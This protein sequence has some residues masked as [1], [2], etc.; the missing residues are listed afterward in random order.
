MF[1]QSC[2]GHIPYFSSEGKIVLSCGDLWFARVAV[3]GNKIAC[4][5]AQ[6]VIFHLALASFANCHHFTDTSKMIGQR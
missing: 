3:L 4:A 2:L 5:F 1:F 6:K